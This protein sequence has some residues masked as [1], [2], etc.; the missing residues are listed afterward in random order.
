MAQRTARPTKPH[1]TTVF[2]T[3]FLKLLDRPVTPLAAAKFFDC[4]KQILLFEV[5]PQLWRDVHLSIGSLPEQKIREPHF[6]GS[7]DKEIGIGI[8]TRVKMFAE[9]CHIDHRSV[10]VPQFDGSKQTF[11][12]VDNL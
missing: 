11:D 4:S 12:S 10:D 2:D 7:A 3:K 9:H 8:V 6:A 1:A 5:R